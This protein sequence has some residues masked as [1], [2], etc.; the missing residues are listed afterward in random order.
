[1]SGSK[2]DISSQKK[3]RCLVIQFARLGDTLQSL[4]ALCAAKQLYPNL[5]IC[6]VA[7][8]NFA[9][10]AKK[11]AWINEVITFPT[12]QIL[13]PIMNGEKTETQGLGDV[14][15]WIAPLV[16]EKWD[17]VVNW[18]YSE[19]S[20]FLTG[21]L[22]ARVKLGYTRRPDSSFSCSD[23]W[24]HYIQA[25]VQSGTDQNIHLTDIL[26]TQLLT[27]LQI[28]CGE[29]VDA[30]NS[31]VTS[32]GFF[33]LQS[34]ENTLGSPWPKAWKDPSKKWFAIQLGAAHASKTWDAV[35][36]AKLANY[37]L[38]RHPEFNL[39]ILGGGSEKG[40]EKTF[41]ANLDSKHL[42][43]GRLFS[44][45]GKTTFDLWAEA[46]GHC[47]W[48]MA[49]DTAAIHLASVLGTRVLNISV[50]PVRWSE[51]GPY[52]N[53]HYVVSSA[54]PCT[55][56]EMR[57]KNAA[58]TCRETV[59]P[60]AAYATFAYAFSEWSHRRQMPI[61]KHFAQ[62]GW[63]K[64]LE[65]VR[66]FR[67][68][69]RA[70]GEG[71]GVS[72]EPMIQRSFTIKDWNAQVM[73]Q[74][75]RSWYCGWV[76]PIGQEMSRSMIN[77]GLIQ[78]LRHLDESSKVFEKICVEAA[79]TSQLFQNK[80][81]SLASDKVMRISDKEILRDLGKK[82]MELD[83]LVERVATANEP[84]LPFS[85]MSKVLMH[86][87]KGDHLADLGRES[88]ESYHLLNQGS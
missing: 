84:L 60:E 55:G 27:A 53:G 65:S 11:V 63:S 22:P 64:E 73:G 24:S 8:E 41:L 5:E 40:L 17:F 54:L 38:N 62:L 16:R 77:P 9:A 18:S 44:M 57:A 66:I 82:L 51:T 14:A 86:N 20:S 67:S 42:S 75:A 56:C 34:A 35:N 39:V 52:G 68:K 48:I 72:Y 61:E 43:A 46:V 2:I 69:I 19:A 21:I 32:K 45:V 33:N 13:R 10:A 49:G 3:I 74:I 78:S 70:S 25:I 36:W 29:P 71:G 37:T 7:H 87:L 30:G 28:H 50:G 1:M 12:E 88:A 59:T 15:R 83:I 81:A 76:P 4:M 23:G 85:R 31:A 47:Q 6:F 26:T 80:S 79:K 58:H